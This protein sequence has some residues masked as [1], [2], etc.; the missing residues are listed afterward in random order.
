MCQIHPA[1]C[2]R[3][4]LGER[5]Y[6]SL[7]FVEVSQLVKEELQI[8]FGNSSPVSRIGKK[9]SNNF[10]K[11]IDSTAELLIKIGKSVLQHTPE[12]E[13]LDSVG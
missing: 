5:A 1:Q 13:A 4:G 7:N 11:V 2:E 10:Q 8:V 3:L 6:E 12:A 9:W